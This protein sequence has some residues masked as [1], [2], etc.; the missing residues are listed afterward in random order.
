MTPFSM[1]KR[2]KLNRMAPPQ[3]DQLERGFRRAMVNFVSFRSVLPASQLACEES[4]PLLDQ[5]VR[6]HAQQANR[7]YLGVATS[8]APPPPWNLAEKRMWPASLIQT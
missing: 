6:A 3:Q 7:G 8:I 1:V 4:A 5:D 2:T